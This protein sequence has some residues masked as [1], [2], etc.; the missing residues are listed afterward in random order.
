MS[1]IITAAK[2]DIS[3]AT[4]PT[5][6][7][8]IIPV[9]NASDFIADCLNSIYNTKID[10]VFE[11]I[12]VDD[13]ST[14]DSAKIVQSFPCRY[15]RIQKSGVASARNF[16]IKKAQGGI[17]FFFDADVRLKK[18]TIARFLKHFQEDKDAHI[19]QGRWDKKSPVPSFSSRFFLLKYTYNFTPLFKGE[20]R[21]EVA[22]LETGCLAIRREVFHYFDG[23]NESYRLSGGEEHEFGMRLLEKYKIYYYPDI[24]VEHAFGN[25]LKTL[26]KIHRRTVNFSILSFKVRKSG[27]LKKHKNS[28]PTQ[29]KVSVIIIYLLLINSFLFL[30]NIRSAL[31]LSSILLLFYFINIF[32]FLAF[33]FRQENIIFALKGAAADFLI[34]LPMLFGLLRGAYIYYILGQRDFKI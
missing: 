32:K 29:N 28:V 27:F 3:Q 17:I 21:I 9:Y 22:N 1:S 13:A 8:I 15:F 19:I 4:L 7:S 18:D 30:F 5:T 10:V 33:L 20:K 14:D 6:I 34:M 31:I 2:V 12:V 24:F 11:V 23:F 16:G 26:G 25:I